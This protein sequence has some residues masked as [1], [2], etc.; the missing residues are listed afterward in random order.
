[1]RKLKA[2]GRL[3]DRLSANGPGITVA[4][5]AMV[6]ALTGAAFAASGSLTGKQKREVKALIKKGAKRG[7][8]GPKGA[9]GDPGAPGAKGATGAPGVKGDKGDT[10]ASGSAGAS[11]KVT[12]VAEGDE[13]FCAELGGALVEEEGNPP[14]TEVCNGEKGANGTPGADGSPWT[15]GG[16]LPA[17]GMLTGTWIASGSGLV[18]TPI[19]FPIHLAGN[20]SNSNV[21]YGSAEEPELEPSPGVKEP[22]EFQKH[23]LNTVT[24]PTGVG[25]VTNPGVRPGDSP[26]TLCIYF[27]NGTSTGVATF[28]GVTKFGTATN[29]G[30]GRAGAVI[31]LNITTPGL[32]GGTFAVSGG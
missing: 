31:R 13:E 11:V 18:E 17:E 32:I 15:A 14:G 30:G 16:T 28:E 25:S 5:I 29:S 22:T 21:Y 27:S 6:V 12:P 7:P 19:S 8:K 26:R 4:V 1:M 24:D 10:G 23:C 20:V 3:K 2:L 9:P